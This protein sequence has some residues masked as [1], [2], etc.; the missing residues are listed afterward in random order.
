MFQ[1]WNLDSFRN[2]VHPH[3]VPSLLMQLCPQS[4]TRQKFKVIF[5][6]F[7]SYLSSKL[8]SSLIQEI[9]LTQCSKHPEYEQFS[10]SSLMDWI[11]ILFHLDYW[12][13]LLTNF[14]AFIFPTHPHLYLHTILYTQRDYSQPWGGGRSKSWNSEI[15][16]GS[17]AVIQV[18]GSECYYHFLHQSASAIMTSLLFLN[19]LFSPV[20]L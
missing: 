13:R 4:C 9:L 17:T 1:N 11:P 18:R 20:S 3:S 16:P 19:K 5:N 14:S 6:I 8:L 2:L 10:S 7:L 12:N 15:C